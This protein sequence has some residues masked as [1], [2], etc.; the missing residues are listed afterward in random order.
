MNRLTHLCVRVRARRKTRENTAQLYKRRVQPCR[1]KRMCMY[2]EKRR[3]KKEERTSFNCSSRPQ[4]YT[5]STCV[6][7]YIRLLICAGDRIRQKA[8]PA[9]YRNLDF[10]HGEVSNNQLSTSNTCAHAYAH[11]YFVY[12]Y[13]HLSDYRLIPYLVE[14]ALTAGYNITDIHYCMFACHL[15]N[16]KKRRCRQHI[17]CDRRANRTMDDDGRE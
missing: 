12:T 8:F 10:T 6:I 2:R 16:K 17:T 13:V 15:S 1:M 11:F 5:R 9:S 14:Y 4:I 3:K 7:S